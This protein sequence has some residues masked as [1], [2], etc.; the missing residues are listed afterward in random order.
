M[1]DVMDKTM[2]LLDSGFDTVS[3]VARYFTGQWD[4]VE[5]YF[6]VGD[7]EIPVA[8]QRYVND[9]TLSIITFYDKGYRQRDI[10]KDSEPWE[11]CEAMAVAAFRRA[12]PRQGVEIVYALE[13]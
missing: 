5:C 10:P 6:R 1:A 3:G 13:A 11:I 4:S 9:D 7:K 2:D 8:V 12:N